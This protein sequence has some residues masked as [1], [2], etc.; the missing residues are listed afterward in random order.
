MNKP[1]YIYVN[2]LFSIPKIYI[3]SSDFDIS[4][5]IAIISAV[6]API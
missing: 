3:K 1:F 2:K 5:T 6:T 4:K